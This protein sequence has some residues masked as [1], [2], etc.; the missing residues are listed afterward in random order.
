LFEVISA[1]K[2]A[3][4]RFRRLAFSKESDFPLL[5]GFDNF[6]R[7]NASRADLHPA[8]T[9]RRKLDANG[10][11]VRIEPTACFVVSV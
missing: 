2:N 6:A 4:H 3:K 5:C 11:Q 7:L 1:K 10:L 8:I 9:A